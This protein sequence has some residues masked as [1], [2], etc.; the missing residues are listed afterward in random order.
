MKSRYSL[1][2]EMLIRTIMSSPH[3]DT[4][5]Y[6]RRAPR[7]PGSTQVAPPADHCVYVTSCFIAITKRAITYSK[8]SLECV[9]KNKL[10]LSLLWGPLH[11]GIANSSCTA[12]LYIMFNLLMNKFVRLE[13]KFHF[14][15]DIVMRPLITCNGHQGAVSD[16]QHT[17]LTQLTKACQRSQALHGEENGDF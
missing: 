8:L 5:R 2:R 9:I 7:H 3:C 10:L 16:S 11:N 13:G 1:F 6:G 15:I 17:P 14:S 4:G 12:A